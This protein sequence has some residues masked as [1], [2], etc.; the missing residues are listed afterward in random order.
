VENPIVITGASGFVGRKLAVKFRDAGFE[1]TALDVNDPK[2]DGV[3]FIYTD[4]SQ[5]MLIDK[6]K[7]PKSASFIHLAALSTDGQCK[8]NPK[9][10]LETNLVGTARVIELATEKEA[11]KF[12]FASSEWVYPERTDDALQKETEFLKLES[13][14]SLYA[15]TKLMGEN[16]LRATCSIP[17]VVLRFGIVYGPRPNPGSAPESIALRVSR[18]EVVKIGSGT[19]SRR[20][21]YVEDLIEG[22]HKA[23]KN[24]EN[25]AY[26][27]FNLSGDQLLSLGEIIEAS[28]RLTKR[29]V[30]IVD[31][32]FSPSI[33]NPDPSKFMNEFQFHFEVDIEEGLSRCLKA[34]GFSY[35]D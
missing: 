2:I 23:V 18:G 14:N 26:Q 33:R 1:V 3:N 25:V 29:R 32:G 7:I 11:I 8:A 34:M 5:E 35:G 31:E 4:I 6:R 20:F 10:A 15:M 28:M 12:V 9:Q 13:L 16:L 30:Q 19:T 22:I 24:S 17:T 27:V 21:I